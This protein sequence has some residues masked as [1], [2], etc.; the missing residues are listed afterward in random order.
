MGCKLMPVNP[1]NLTNKEEAVHMIRTGLSIVHGEKIIVLA[2]NE[3]LAKAIDELAAFPA[4]VIKIIGLTEQ[5]PT[6]WT[7]FEDLVHRKEALTN[8][9]GHTNNAIHDKSTAVDMSASPKGGT[10]MFTSGTTSLPKGV[11]HPYQQNFARVMPYQVETKAEQRVV[12]ESRFCCSLPNNH[13]MGWLGITW[14]LTAG[15]ALVVP[16]PAFD[17]AVVLRAML[18]EKVTHTILVPTMVHALVAAKSASPQFGSYPLKNMKS[19]LLGGSSLDPETMRLLTKDLGAQGGVHFWGCTEGLLTRGSWASD[20]AEI[21]DKHE[22]TV[23]WP[24]PGYTLKIVD[25]ETGQIVPRNVLGELE[26]SGTTIAAP[27]IGGVGKDVWYRDE[28]GVLW[29]KTGDQAR[30]DEQGRIFI[31]GR[32][33]DM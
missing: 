8:G 15:A 3:Q 26:G 1:R 30:M 12:P 4:D 31:S 10:I 21:E 23:G 28:A 22:L 13:A 24:L 25:P 18:D 9:N 19:V 32:Y 5:Q 11:W 16:G 29:Y 20:P 6:G 33:K 2:G 27:Y 7:S 17:P 14:P